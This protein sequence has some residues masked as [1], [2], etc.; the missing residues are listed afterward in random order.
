MVRRLQLTRLHQ[1]PH[2][3]EHDVVRHVR[4]DKAANRSIKRHKS[5]RGDKYGKGRSRG[6]QLKAKVK[7][8]REMIKEA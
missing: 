8:E 7:G 6:I 4:F 3:G 1:V 5:G 2:Q